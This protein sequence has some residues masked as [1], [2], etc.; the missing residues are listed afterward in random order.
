MRAIA[1]SPRHRPR[2]EPARVCWRKDLAVPHES[3][4][5]RCNKLEVFNRA[6]SEDIRGDLRDPRAV[7]ELAYERGAVAGDS[8]VAGILDHKKLLNYSAKDS[9]RTLGVLADYMPALEKSRSRRDLWSSGLLRYCPLCLKAGVHVTYFQFIFVNR[10]PVHRVR[11]DTR[12]PSCERRI[13]YIYGAPRAAR[14][15]AC[16]CG[17]KLW[18]WEKTPTNRVTPA[19]KVGHAR[20]GEWTTKA[21]SLAEGLHH[22]W[23]F[24]H[25]NPLT[26][27]PF[28]SFVSFVQPRLGR[29]TANYKP[30][31]TRY[32]TSTRIAPIAARTTESER[33][34]LVAT[35]KCICRHFY[36]RY[37]RRHR[38]AIRVLAKSTCRPL[39]GDFGELEWARP[40][41]L[42]ASA[43][44]AW[45]MYWEGL[46]SPNDVFRPRDNYHRPTAPARLYWTDFLAQRC[47]NLVSF[48][49]LNV[50]KTLATHIRV[51]WFARTCLSV[52]DECLWDINYL[53]REKPRKTGH[54][55]SFTTKTINGAMTPLML[56]I[57]ERDGTTTLHWLS[58]FSSQRDLPPIAYAIANPPSNGEHMRFRQAKRAI[59]DQVS[60]A[61]CEVEPKPSESFITRIMVTDKIK[62]LTAARAKLA[63]LKQ[64]VERALPREL[65]ELPAKYGFDSIK[66]FANAVRTA[67][68]APGKRRGRPPGAKA[69][70]AVKPPGRKKRRKRAVITDETRALVKKLV[71]EGKTGPE[72]AKAAGISLPSVQNV[73]T[74]LGLTRRRAAR[75]K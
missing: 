5:C 21:M 64:A 45:R 22:P 42:A 41:G 32:I 62:E 69:K 48:P 54:A 11:L 59:F 34:R 10:C 51:R 47:H 60:K 74:S 4:W 14:R 44:L 18:D 1:V 66:E 36:R 27:T 71:G 46:K 13:E 20:A 73:K 30:E 8:R 50:A 15:F 3:L 56:P 72:I 67:A 55:W 23:C 37:L 68:A 16:R 9:V 49:R 70:A 2:P 31:I 17:R 33:T 53:F 6:D 25:D 63:E 35:Y 39:Y 75:T 7:R 65:A 29:L 38:R 40:F 24:G 57:V 12:C 43:F 61:L 19:M 52:F 28:A 26:L 58:Y